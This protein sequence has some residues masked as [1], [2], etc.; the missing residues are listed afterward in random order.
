MNMQGKNIET[1][2]IE[3]LFS[4]STG[5]T[6]PILMDIQ[7]DKLVWEDDDLGQENGH[8]RIINDTTP[9]VYQG[10]RYMSSVFNFKPPVEDGKKVGN[11]NVSISA[12]DQ[13]IIKIIRGIDDVPPKAFLDACFAKRGTGNDLSFIFSKLYHYEFKM[14]SASW[15]ETVAQWELV[16]DDVMNNNVPKDLGTTVRCPAARE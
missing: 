6:I 13:R 8:L 9:V 15:N 14:T 10:K 3:E 1:W 11:T 2:T 7:H 16:F 5:G 12:L 4:Q